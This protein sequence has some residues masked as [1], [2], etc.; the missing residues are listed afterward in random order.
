MLPVQVVRYYAQSTFSGYLPTD[1]SMLT[2]LTAGAI[3]QNCATTFILHIEANKKGALPDIVQALK[4]ADTARKI[5]CQLVGSMEGDAGALC[6]CMHCSALDEKEE[7]AKA[8]EAKWEARLS[9][10]HAKLLEE[11]ADKERIVQHCQELEKQRDAAI[12]GLREQYEARQAEMQLE[13]ALLRKQETLQ[14]TRTEKSSLQAEELLRRANVQMEG[15]GGLAML[16]DEKEQAVESRL[17][18]EKM[19]AHAKAETQR[20]LSLNEQLQL[21]IHT[22][23]QEAR[24]AAEALQR[25]LETAE[26]SYETLKKEHASA[27]AEMQLQGSKEKEKQAE[28]LK[29]LEHE[30]DSLKQNYKTL[31]T[32]NKQLE[33]NLETTRTQLHTALTMAEET[34]KQLEHANQRQGETSSL[35]GELRRVEAE[36]RKLKVAWCAAARVSVH[37][38]YG[39]RSNWEEQPTVPK[40]RK[41]ANDANAQKQTAKKGRKKADDALL[42]PSRTKKAKQPSGHSATTLTDAEAPPNESNAAAMPDAA[43]QSNDAVEAASER[44]PLHQVPPP[45]LNSDSNAASKTTS[46]PSDNNKKRRKLLSSR[47]T[48]NDT[49]AKAGNPALPGIRIGFSRN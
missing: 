37:D 29:V 11:Q 10:L 24:A 36:N 12:E 42:S 35:S 17:V 7:Q 2:R 40:K 4:F 6:S 32:I 45:Q 49:D 28:R 9:E 33:S 23:E 39:H 13:V 47:T 20:V 1:N 19:L 44:K 46:A 43:A 34:Q 41:N 3:G 8:R 25:K 14:T 22:Q 38:H 18:L 30:H 15:T 26:N 21:A 48:N 31:E 16:E 5:R 27:K